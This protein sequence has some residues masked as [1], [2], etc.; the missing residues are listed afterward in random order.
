MSKTLIFLHG[1]PGYGEYLEEFFSKSLSTY[2]SCIFYEQLR[3]HPIAIEDLIQQLL[4][5]MGTE[6]SDIYL[7]GHSWGGVLAMETYRRTLDHRVKGIV[8][9]GSYLC[10]SE[11]TVEYEK[12]LEILGFKNPTTEQVF[13]TSQELDISPDFPKRLADSFDEKICDQIERDFFGQYDV[14]EFV[15][16]I[17][18]PVL[19]IFG[20]KDIRVPARR[21]RT[22]ADL[23][24]EVRNLE[25][26]SAAHFPFIL[27]EHRARVI[28][29]IRDFVGN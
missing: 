16:T 29:A 19:N 4:V 1:G 27:P 21:L 18:I 28:S 14:R 25:I 7:I 10:A 5:K 8:L 9:I 11:V 15:K 3:K 23:S 2:L 6:A 20:E 12:E 24:N 13:F 26:E 22:Y 17:S